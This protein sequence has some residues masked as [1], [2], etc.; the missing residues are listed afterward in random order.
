MW[1]FVVWYL[2]GVFPI[3]G[4]VYFFK[5]RLL[6]KDLFPALICGTLGLIST[7]LCLF[8]FAFELILNSNKEWMNK[9]IL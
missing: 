2:C 7:F 6:V 5:K 1:G 8:A 4:Y 3:L 9:R